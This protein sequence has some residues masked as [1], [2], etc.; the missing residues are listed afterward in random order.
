MTITRIRTTV[1]TLVAALLLAAVVAPVASAGRVPGDIAV[2]GE[3]LA[4]GE[5]PRNFGPAPYPA[6]YFSR[7]LTVA[8]DKMWVGA[9][10]LM[11]PG[12]YGKGY[13]FEYRVWGDDPVWDDLRKGPVH[14]QPLLQ[15]PYSDADMLYISEKLDN[16]NVSRLLD[17]DDSPFDDRDEIY[18]AIRLVDSSGKTVRAGETNRVYG[19]W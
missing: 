18:V 1:V 6:G 10:V 2:G 9:G 5:N 14:V 16:I 12:A 11:E 15:G 17:E 13:R 3:L 8:D 7:T 19:Y 4:Q